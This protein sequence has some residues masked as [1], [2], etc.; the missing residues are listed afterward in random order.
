MMLLR[1]FRPNETVESLF[2]ID[3]QRLFAAGKRA[4]LFDLDW[5]LGGYRSRRLQPEV[6][7]L[8]EGLI[9]IGF[10]VGILTNRRRMKDDPV[11]AILAQRYPLLHTAGKPAKKGFLS[12]LEQLETPGEQAVMIGDR[13]LTDIIGANRLG[14]YSIKVRSTSGVDRGNC[15]GCHR[16]C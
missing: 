12:L 3:Y 8:L 13:I 10:K 9:R 5:T 11:I 4:L 7:Q 15:A 14:I 16:G 6:A 1:L 2:E